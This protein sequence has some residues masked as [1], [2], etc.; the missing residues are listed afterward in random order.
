LRLDL[1]DWFDYLKPDEATQIFLQKIIPCIEKSDTVMRR[2]VTPH[3]RL[4][5]TPWFLATGKIYEH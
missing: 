2:A 1:R 5:V 4:S 3:E